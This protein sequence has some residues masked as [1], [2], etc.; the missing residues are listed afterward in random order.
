MSDWTKKLPEA[1]QDFIAG[2]KVDEVECI[3][4]DMAGVARGKAMPASKFA[5]QTQF[6]LPNSIFFQ[7]ITGD[8]GEAAGPTRSSCKRSRANGPTARST[9][10]PN[11]T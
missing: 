2:R 1:A 10:S 11:P 7:T 8:W 6:F 4:G 9:P 3:I 5:T